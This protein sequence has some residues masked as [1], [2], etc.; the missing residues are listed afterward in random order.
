M[1][2]ITEANLQA[3]VDRI[4]RITHSPLEQ[5]TKVGTEYQ[6]NVGNYHLD[7]AYGGVSLCRMQNKSGGVE[8]VL[9]TGHTTK[10]ELYDQLHAFIRGLE[11]M[12]ELQRKAVAA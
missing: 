5:Y 2:R 6:S 3:V 12:E 7:H 1:T 11:A 9:R 8:D 4:N 10:R